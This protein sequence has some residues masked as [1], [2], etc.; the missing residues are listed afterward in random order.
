MVFI[1]ANL[2]KQDMELLIAVKDEN[3]TSGDRVRL[4]FE[5]FGF[6]MYSKQCLQ[7]IYQQLM[8]CFYSL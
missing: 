3:H 5:Y 7:L 2:Q 4:T 1:T 6:E 8:I